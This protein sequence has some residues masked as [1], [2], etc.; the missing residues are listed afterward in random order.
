MRIL[1]RVATLVAITA[2][3]DAA[4]PRAVAPV[5]TSVTVAANPHNVLSA[6]VSVKVTGADSVAVRFRLANGPSTSETTPAAEPQSDSVTIPVLGMLADKRYLLNAVAWW[7]NGKVIGDDIDFTTGSLPPDLPQYAASGADP[8]PGFVVFAAGV[9]GIV[10]DNLG[11]IVWYRRFP[12]GPGLNFMAQPDGHYA[13][14]PSTPDPGGPATWLELD[15]LGN[16]TRTLGCAN[17]LVPRPHD[18]IS[19]REGDYW[20]L[21]DESRTMDLSE[22]GGL[23]NAVVTGT[24]VQHL[25]SAGNLLFQWS[26]FEHFAITDGSPDDLK[27]TKVNWTHGNGLE[28]DTDGNLLVSFRNLNEITKID[29]ATGAVIWRMGGRRNQFTFSGSSSPAFSG[30]HGVRVSATGEVAILDN[31]GTPGESRA[32]HYAID[33][34]SHTARLTRYYSPLPHVVTLIG[35]SVQRLDGGRTLVSFGTAG[36]VVEYDAAGAVKWTIDGNPGYVFR[37]QRILSLYAPGVGTAR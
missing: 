36:R 6:V 11:R 23:S 20:L 18:L 2:C 3:A 30:Q 33:A 21:C 25:D 19:K 27:G 26:P 10:I 31:I 15:P 37:A 12:Y 35:G 28:F 7:S 13:A 24:A 1:P 16:I 17:G 4:G 8:S 14:R 29:V 5:V 34:A 32:E 9:Y 22:V